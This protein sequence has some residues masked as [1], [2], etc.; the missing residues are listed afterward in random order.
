MLRAVQHMHA[1]FFLMASDSYST[2]DVLER[3]R[4]CCAVIKIYLFRSCCGQSD[5]LWCLALALQGRNDAV[6]VPKCPLPGCI[7]LQANSFALIGVEI[8][9][10][11]NPEMVN[12]AQAQFIA[13]GL[14]SYNAYMQV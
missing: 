12:H 8:K 13:W 3:T 4:V 6:F 7:F 14:Q 2:I 10:S 5:Y 11:L 9:E 1:S